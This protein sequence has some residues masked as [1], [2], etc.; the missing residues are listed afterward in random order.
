MFIFMFG[1]NSLAENCLSSLKQRL[2]VRVSVSAEVVY[3]CPQSY[4]W[5]DVQGPACSGLN[6]Q[7]QCVH[8]T[9]DDTLIHKH[10]VD[11]AK[12]I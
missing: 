7:L 4:T 1:D 3:T 9:S 12:R 10:G 2:H 11:E 6:V 5:K 8:R